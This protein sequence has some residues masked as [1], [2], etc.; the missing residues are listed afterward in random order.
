M[1]SF[2]QLPPAHSNPYLVPAPP[3]PPANTHPCT[4]GWVLAGNGLATR[5]TAPWPPRPPLSCSL[6]S[7]GLAHA[8]SPRPDVHIW[9]C[10]TAAPKGPCYWN[11]KIFPK[12]SDLCL[13]LTLKPHLSWPSLSLPPSGPGSQ[14]LQLASHPMCTGIMP[15]MLFPDTWRHSASWRSLTPHH[16]FSPEVV[17][18]NGILPTEQNMLILFP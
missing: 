3:Q 8:P 14:H 13:D 17:S 9:C 18:G 12:R 11:T 1:G 6:A 15:Q 4:L 5:T 16:G 7:H 10:Q 2:L